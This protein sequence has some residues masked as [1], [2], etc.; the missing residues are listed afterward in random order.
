MER[1][2]R[3]PPLKL[4]GL[5][6]QQTRTVGTQTI[7]DLSNISNNWFEERSVTPSLSET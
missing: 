6:L 4:G 3:K 7:E 1:A 5:E 2:T